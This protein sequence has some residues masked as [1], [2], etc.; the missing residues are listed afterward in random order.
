[1]TVGMLGMAFKE[2]SDDIRSSLSYK[3]K[4]ILRFKAKTVLCHDPYVHRRLGT[5]P[6][7][8]VLGAVR[9]PDSVGPAPGLPGA[10][11]GRPADRHLGH[12]R[13]RHGPVKPRVS[14]I[15]MAY[16]EGEAIVPYLERLLDVGRPP[17]RGSRGLRLARRHDRP[18]D[19]EVRNEPTHG[20]SPCST[21]TDRARQ[22]HPVRIRP[23]RP[24]MSWS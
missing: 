8:E 10:R 7:E 5:A 12:A 4:R 20:W 15:V 17:V 24:P 14:V 3:L 1:M 13:E 19:R 23:R 16:N 22:R 6:L 11:G 9:S 21:P 18:V 2:E